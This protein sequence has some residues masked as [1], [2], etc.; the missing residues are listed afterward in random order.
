MIIG[1]IAGASARGGFAGL[2]AEARDLLAYDDVTVHVLSPAGGASDLLPASAA[3]HALTASRRDVRAMARAIRQWH[4]A[5]RPDVVHL[6]GRAAGIGGRVGLWTAKTPIAY[7]PHGGFPPAHAVERR[8]E[9]VVQKV[10]RR[11]T[12]LYVM[13]SE[14]ERSG[15]AA[16][17]GFGQSPVVV[18]PNTV[19]PVDV[20]RRAAGCEWLHDAAVVV[21]G[22]YHPLK[23]PLDV[24]EALQRVDPPRPTVLFVGDSSWDGGAYRARVERTAS[25]LDVVDSVA[26]GDEV[27]AVIAGLAHSELVLFPSALEGLPFIALEASAVG[28]AVAWSDIAA[29]REV[30]GEHGQRF[31]V[32]DVASIAGILASRDAW[33]TWRIPEQDA[34]ALHARSAAHR[35][36][37]LA[38]LLALARRGP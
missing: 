10:L 30:F 32:G 27:A 16:E 19:D 24:L 2:V 28:A 33:P 1:L 17:Y 7:T 26:F 9:V 14:S 15:F 25:E 21:P 36:D 3:H 6:H 31:A 20:R 34:T 23:R 11:R 5:V 12:N 29:H 37:A 35:R 18:M 4:D 22:A 13:V 8:V 38:S